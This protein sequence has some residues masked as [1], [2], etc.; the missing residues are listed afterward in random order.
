MSE[1]GSDAEVS[2]DMFANLVPEKPQQAF[3]KKNTAFNWMKKKPD[4]P[5][6]LKESQSRRGNR[7]RRRSREKRDEVRRLK[8]RGQ[9]ATRVWIWGG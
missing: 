5:K 2:A 3:K 4:V 9:R 1:P 7:E 8:H 6:K